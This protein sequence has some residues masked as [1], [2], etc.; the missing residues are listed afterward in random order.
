MADILD[1]R[2]S[3]NH[4][5]VIDRAVEQLGQG[6]LVAFPTDTTYGVAAS[7][8][9]PEAVERLARLKPDAE[10]SLTLAIPSAGQALDWVPEMSVLG[11]RLTRRCWPGPVR[12]VFGEGITHGL[13]SRLPDA[14]RRSVCCDGQLSLYVPGHDAITEALLF[15]PAP[16][17]LATA[18]GP[19][20][21]GAIT[22]QQ[23]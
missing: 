12:L 16:L 11:R 13:A 15:L 5:A 8:L 4:R 22:P 23:V 6:Q 20:E 14:V 7:V 2:L 3:T 9:V 17:V 18:R 10:P 21:A 19:G 1:W